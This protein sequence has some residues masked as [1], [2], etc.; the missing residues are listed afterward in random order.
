MYKGSRKGR[1]RMMGFLDNLEA[2]IDFEEDIDKEKAE[3][4]DS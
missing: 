1:E 4:E 2:W 3:D